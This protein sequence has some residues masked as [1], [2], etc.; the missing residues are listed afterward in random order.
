[1]KLE[2]V[3]VDGDG[4]PDRRRRSPKALGPIDGIV[5]FPF[6]ARYK[7]T[8]DYQK[9]ELTLHAQRLRPRRRDEG[10]MEKLMGA[11][12]ASKSRGR[13]RPPRLWGFAVDKDSGRRGRG[14]H[15]EG[16]DRRSAAAAGGLKAG[17]RLLTL[18]GRWTDSIGDTFSA[19]SSVKPGQ[20]AVLVVKRGGKE[21]ELTVK[22]AKGT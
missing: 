14:R 9:K 1:M 21:V 12:R 11:R 2:K 4:P 6:F 20:A 19:A 7:T 13:A 5:G 8:V 16:R 17:D 22:P 18:D 10:L 15:G 3:P